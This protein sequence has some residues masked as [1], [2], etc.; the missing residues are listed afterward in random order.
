MFRF[1]FSSITEFLIMNSITEILIIYRL[2]VGSGP[3]F[4]QNEV[5]KYVMDQEFFPE[6]AAFSSMNVDKATWKINNRARPNYIKAHTSGTEEQGN[7]MIKPLQGQNSLTF[8]A[9][10]CEDVKISMLP[11]NVPDINYEITIGTLSNSVTT[12]LK[13]STVKR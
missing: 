5:M 6:A 10:A 13:S 7:V 2:T 8:S 9:K 11:E 3:F 12:L 1:L 4:G